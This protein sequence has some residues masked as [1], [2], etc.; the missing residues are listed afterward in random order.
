VPQDVLCACSTFFTKALKEDRFLEGAA[1]LITLPEETA[2]VFE[3]FVAFAYEGLLSFSKDSLSSAESRA[4]AFQYVLEIWNFGE[5]YMLPHLQD[6][7]TTSACVFLDYDD[8]PFTVLVQCFDAAATETC[9]F[10]T[11]IADSA[12]YR[13]SKDKDG[14]GC[15]V[16]RLFAGSSGF[17]RAFYSSQVAAAALRAGDFPRYRRPVKAGEELYKTGPSEIQWRDDEPGLFCHSSL[18]DPNQQVDCGNC[19]LYDTADFAGRAR[20]RSCRQFAYCQCHRGQWSIECN[21]CRHE[22]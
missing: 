16:E 21:D 14:V 12:V 6:A 7:A 19:G 15:E 1:K 20:C 17:L 9:P 10:R 18:W 22:S 4:E 8:I 2:R 3:A 13:M 5:K 11:I